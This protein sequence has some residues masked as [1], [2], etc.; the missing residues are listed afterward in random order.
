MTSRPR[1][2]VQCHW[3]PE[4]VGTRVRARRGQ[5]GQ[6]RATSLDAAGLAAVACPV[7]RGR[8]I[9]QAARAKGNL[10]RD[11]ARIR[12][13]AAAEARTAGLTVSHLAA[14]WAITSRRLKQVLQDGAPRDCAS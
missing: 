3:T 7:E 4:G 13:A 9:C 6:H 10:T 11:L 2:H 14:E 5:S 12:R 8:L 1:H